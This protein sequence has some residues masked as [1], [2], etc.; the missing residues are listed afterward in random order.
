MAKVV[1]LSTITC[2]IF[3]IILA[4][5]LMMFITKDT[6][7]PFTGL[8]NTKPLLLSNLKNNTSNQD[9]RKL[10]KIN[11]ISKA[12][13]SIDLGYSGFFTVP[14][15]LGSGSPPATEE[16]N[17]NIF[18]WYQPNENYDAN[19]QKNTDFVLWLQGGPGAP[20]TFGALNEMG[21]WYVDP[22]T[23]D[24]KNRCFTW[25]KTRNCLYV[26]QPVQTGFSF[27]TDSTGKHPKKI[28]Y[29]TTSRI[30]MEQIL[31]VYLQFRDV[32]PEIKDSPFVIGGES[33][34]GLYT[35]NLGRVVYEY[36]NQ[37]YI[38]KYK[39]PFH[40]INFKALLCGDPVM[41]WSVQMPTYPDTLYSM[42]VIMGEEKQHL[43]NI[44][45]KGVAAIK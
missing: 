40:P 43:T 14:V 29:I 33:Y 10:S 4:L 12:N 21:R 9:L 28:T 11:Y 24:L 20:G 8:D 37:Q 39:T 42:G 34:G 38:P 32:F 6:I 2:I 18:F 26:D 15:T 36:N 7:V 25:G 31:E 22:V 3:V 45:K 1:D 13:K 44:Y 5:M 27:Q 35:P 19:D 23:K 41:D 17:N 16:R 30:A